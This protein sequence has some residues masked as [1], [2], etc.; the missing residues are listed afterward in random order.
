[1]AL[2]CVQFNQ[3]GP[4]PTPGKVNYYFNNGDAVAAN[5]CSGMNV[6]DYWGCI[7]KRRWLDLE[8]LGVSSS[9]GAF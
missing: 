5:T 3:V 1:M 7:C 6:N 8:R 4:I 9:S 2:G